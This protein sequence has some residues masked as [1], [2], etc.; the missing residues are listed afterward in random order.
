[1][2]R[3]RPRGCESDVAAKLKVIGVK[4]MWWRRD[5]ARRLGEQARGKECHMAALRAYGGFARAGTRALKL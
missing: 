1:M 3:L 4:K 5:G 2:Q